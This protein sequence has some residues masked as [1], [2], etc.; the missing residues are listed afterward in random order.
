MAPFRHVLSFLE[1]V[2]FTP[3]NGV[4]VCRPKQNCQ[5]RSRIPPIEDLAGVDA[6]KITLDLLYGECVDWAK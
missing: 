2:N 4:G 6:G 1:R 3:N 5:R